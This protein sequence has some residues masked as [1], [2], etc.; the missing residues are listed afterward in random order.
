MS[1]R[2]QPWSDEQAEHGRILV[3]SDNPISQAIASIATAV[4]R[5][6]H[7]EAAD[8]GGPGLD[9][10]PGD[11][12]VLCDHDAPD[13][14]ATLRAART[15]PRV[16]TAAARR[17]VRAPSRWWRRSWPTPTTAP[18]ARCATTH[19]VHVGGARRR[20]AGAPVPR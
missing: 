15:C 12:V 1:M 6:V 2:Q 5:N 4:G 7:V 11:A 9:P 19:D 10:R 18:A 16:P 13:A 8:D 3:L 20:L 14:P 17:P